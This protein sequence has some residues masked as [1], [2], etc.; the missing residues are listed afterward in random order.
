MK[1]GRVPADFG[2]EARQNQALTNWSRRVMRAA[3]QHSGE[4]AAVRHPQIGSRVLHSHS[5][6]EWLNGRSRSNVKHVPTLAGIAERQ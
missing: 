3:P 6:A 2:N 4:G 1:P 5:V